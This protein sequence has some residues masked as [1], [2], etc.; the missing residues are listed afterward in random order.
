MSDCRAFSFFE[1][2]PGCWAYSHCVPFNLEKRN[3]TILLK[4]QTFRNTENVTPCCSTSCLSSSIETISCLFSS[5]VRLSPCLKASLKFV[6][7]HQEFLRHERLHDIKLGDAKL[8][9]T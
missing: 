8:L 2:L 3:Y 5:Q 4:K 9:T 6:E 7:V 1:T